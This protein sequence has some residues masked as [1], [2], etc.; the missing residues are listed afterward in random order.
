MRKLTA[1]ALCGAVSLGLTGC[2][3]A[4]QVISLSEQSHLQ[5]RTPL[6]RSALVRVLDER[7][8]GGQHLGTRGGREPASSPL[9]ADKALAEVLTARL[10]SSLA[11]LGYGNEGASINDPLKLQLSIQE[12]NYHCNE[13]VIVSECGIDMQFL[14]TVIDGNTT[15]RKPYGIK[16]VRSL[17]ASPVP[18]YNKKWLDEKLDE[19]WQYMFS[20]P[21]LKQVLGLH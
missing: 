17:A 8:L 4:P 2:V 1:L 9:M 14:M 12:F 3:L 5:E 15:F 21:E 7:A 20:D 11:Q 16:E 10:Q 19:V 18:E 13:G 6:M